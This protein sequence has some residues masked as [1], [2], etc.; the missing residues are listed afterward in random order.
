MINQSLTTA[1]LRKINKKFREKD[2][3]H[4]WPVCNKFNISERAIRKAR[5]YGPYDSAFEYQ[6]VLEHITSTIVNDPK[7]F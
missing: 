4:L 5:L 1:E 6:T 2:E 7:N 3:S